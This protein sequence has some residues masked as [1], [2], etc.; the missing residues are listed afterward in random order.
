MRGL[1]YARSPSPPAG[2]YYGWAPICNQKGAGC[3]VVAAVSTWD[4]DA[5]TKGSVGYWAWNAGFFNNMVFS[6]K[7]LPYTP[8]PDDIGYLRQLIKTVRAKYPII[9]PK[10]VYVVGF[11]VGAFMAS[12]AAV[13]LSDIVAAVSINSGSLQSSL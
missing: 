6:K 8:Y 1:N 7:P 3:I 9:N 2:K 4:P 12:L 13:D 11:S 10:K 5:T